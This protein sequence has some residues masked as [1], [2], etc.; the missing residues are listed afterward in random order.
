[1]RNQ[2]I[3]KIIAIVSFITLTIGILAAWNKPAA[4]YEASIYSST[5][6]IFWIAIAFCLISGLTMFVVQV[7][8][9]KDVQNADFPIAPSLMIFLSFAA[10]LSLVIIRGY[11]IWGSGDPLTHLGIIREVTVTGHVDNQ[12]I[13]PVTHIFVAQCS[14]ICNISI[15]TLS[16]LIPFLFGLLSVPYT[17]CL[18]KAILPEKRQVILATILSMTFLGGWYLSLTPNHLSNLMFPFALFLL[19][20]S[21]SPYEMRWKILFVP[22][23]FLFPPFHVIPAFALLL[24]LLVIPLTNRI[25]NKWNRK[26]SV[27]H[28]DEKMIS[29]FGNTTWIL[30]IWTISWISSFYI[31]NR[32]IIRIYALIE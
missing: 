23:V 3:T 26:D 9:N 22:I 6:V 14:Q 27:S 4:G 19:L 16:K 31:W 30:L 28:N 24:A 18:A 11:A 1:M 13:Y 17:Y 20:K 12:N 10:V 5:P 15:S 7:F 32:S 21:L 25:L 2:K 8:L 29:R